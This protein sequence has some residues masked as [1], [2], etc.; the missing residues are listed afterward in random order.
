MSHQT[1]HS[2]FEPISARRRLG[3][4]PNTCTARMTALGENTGYR[5]GPWHAEHRHNHILLT[6]DR[7]KT[8]ARTTTWFDKLIKD[9]TKMRVAKGRENIANG[10]LATKA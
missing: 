1:R 5:W 7:A 9:N 6:P 8:I 3:E 10:C 4:P 2:C